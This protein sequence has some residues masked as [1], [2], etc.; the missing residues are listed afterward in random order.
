LAARIPARL[1][2]A[3]GRRFGLT[4]GTAF[5]G[6]GALAWWR[7]HGFE[8]GAAVGI[9][10]ALVGMGLFAPAR[11]GLIYRLWMGLAAV[12]SRITTPVFLGVVYFA[13]VMP[14]GLARRLMGRNAL[15]RRP[16]GD[17]FWI[18]RA[19]DAERRAGMER[20]F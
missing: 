4:V 18:P 15:R 1:S 2:G 19:A 7:G 6:L 10:L 5:T 13:V 17:T 16:T 14:T 8:A 9:G 12:M 11:L 3:E 20:Q